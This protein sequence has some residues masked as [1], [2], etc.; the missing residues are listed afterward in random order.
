MVR[1]TA[2]C[3]ALS[4]AGAAVVAPAS[5]AAQQASP[6][7]V[8]GAGDGVQVIIYGQ[9]EAGVTTRVKADGT[10]VMPFI[11]TLKVDGLTNITLA[12]RIADSMVSGG[13]LRD[14]LVNVEITQ[15]V[16]KVVNVAGRVTNPGIVPLDQPYRALEVLLRSGWIRDNGANYVFLRRPG[17]A[18]RR[19]A[20]E[21][22]VRG[23]YEKDPLMQPGD[24]LY[25]P[26]ADNFY[27]YGAINQSGSFPILPGMTVRQALALAGGVS[28]TGSI[29]KVSLLRGDAKE[30]D[31]DLSQKLQ[32]ND[33]LVVKERLF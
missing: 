30:V 24:T 17:Q 25:V 18:E 12:K 11:G 7:Y 33:V 3:F 10:I 22:L 27:V 6:G 1:S 19:L 5:V 32:K 8:L 9:P 14:P 16:S 2:V 15:Y 31:A 4:L 29:N 28:A 20:V 13:Y 26:D 23:D 21:E